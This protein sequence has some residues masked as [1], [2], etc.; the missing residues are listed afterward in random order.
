MNKELKIIDLLNMIAE[1]KKVPKKIKWG[2]HYLEWFVYEY[3]AKNELGEPMLSELVGYGARGINDTVEI[4]E[5]DNNKIE[6]LKIEQDGQTSN[7]FYLT[8]EN[9]TKCYL[10]KHSKMIAEKINEIIDKINTLQN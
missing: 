3:K 4:I 7:N 2:E 10:T 5:E 1:G 8:N 9:G 6:K